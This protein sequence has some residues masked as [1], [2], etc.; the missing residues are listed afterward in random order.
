MEKSYYDTYKKH[1][2]QEHFTEENLKNISIYDNNT[3]LDL[4][5]TFF[6]ICYYDFYTK[7]TEDSNKIIKLC[8]QVYNVEKFN[9]ISPIL[10]KLIKFM[11]NGENW[12]ISFSKAKM[13]KCIK[14]NSQQSFEPKYNSI[15][16]LSGGL[17]S[18]AGAGQEINSKTIFVTFATN[19]TEKSKAKNSYNNYISRICVN[20]T[21]RI[22]KKRNLNYKTHLTQRTRSLIFIASC[23]IYAD[24]YKINKIK[25][26]E[27]GIMTLN[28]SFFFRRKVTRT[29]HPKTL[30]YI[31]S[32][33]KELDLKIEV[34]NPFNFLTKKEVINLI[35]REWDE[36]IKNTKTCSKMPASKAFYNHKK[37]GYCHC[38]I[39]A[40]C[41]LRQ[42]SI[43]NSIKKE[44]DVKYIVPIE[45]LNINKKKNYEKESGISNDV[46]YIEDL[47]K[48]RYIE[49]KSLIEYY[50][51][52]QKNIINGEIYKYLNL[53]PKYFKNKNYKIQYDKMLYNFSSE[54]EK[55]IN[56]LD[57]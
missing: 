1:P 25:I 5:D 56:Y 48:Y 53:H 29:T 13:Q 46:K 12:E 3:I 22:I 40:A 43:Y 21:H 38:G 44:L 52:F 4:I 35:P 42:I 50:K 20:S 37:Q 32:I 23:L 14:Q 47:C 8:I 24:Y 27:N 2:Y 45:L 39:C 31:N 9:K 54:I 49:K 11:T 6:S 55:Y 30:F 28:P 36:L 17:D 51:L 26:Y 15:A 7:R 10:N 16:L 18:L 34:T 41:I 19:K 33:F 57:K